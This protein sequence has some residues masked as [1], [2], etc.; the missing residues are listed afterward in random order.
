MTFLSLS[1]SMAI[2]G[3]GCAQKA[4]PPIVGGTSTQSSGGV[5]RS[6]LPSGVGIP[7]NTLQ[8]SIPLD[9]AI[10]DTPPYF[11]F[12]EENSRSKPVT[13]IN[14]G[15]NTGIP[16]PAPTAAGGGITPGGGVTGVPLPPLMVGGP[17][18]GGLV[19]IATPSS[20]KALL[21]MLSEPEVRRTLTVAS[22]ADR[23]LKITDILSAHRQ[24]SIFFSFNFC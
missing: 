17:K 2:L 24:V 1:L 5:G 14:I 9:K 8:S 23:A 10:S 15:T 20:D 6:L 4:L 7:L 16:L 18:S 11:V 19:R 3:I 22:R 21:R 12:F 13:N